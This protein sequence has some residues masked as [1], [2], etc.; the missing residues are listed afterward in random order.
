VGDVGLAVAEAG[1]GG[2]PLLLVHG[3]TGAKEDF[4]DFLDRLADLGWH[5]V[6]PDLR[7]HGASDH[8]AG[9]AAY[10]P[11]TFVADLLAL[12][13]ALAWR[14]FALVGHSMGGALGQ[15]LALDHPE[16]VAALV[17]VSTFHGPLSL[18]PQLV[19]MGVAIVHHGG[20]PALSAAQAARRDADPAASAAYRRMA[21]ARPDH[22]ARLENKLLACSTDMWLAMAPRF[23]AW[24]DTLDE[25]RGLA[26]PVLVVVGSDDD[27]MLG[28]SERLAAA[29]PGCRLEVM[30][31]V[32]HVP[33][34]EDPDRWWGLVV[35]FLEGVGRAMQ[36]D[37]PP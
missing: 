24:P 26:M 1:A 3:F 27:A 35:P 13:D 19:E 21:D 12:A 9:Q 30:A 11:E 2:R 17:L 16:R 5:A 37:G 18:D 8:P 20:M 32:R 25:L 7:G 28:Q 33:Q 15:R 23:L 31:G 10:S 6:A 14:R 29:I 22:V 34:I 36:Q 4:T